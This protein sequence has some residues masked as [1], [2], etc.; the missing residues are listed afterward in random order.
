MSLFKVVQI[1]ET[2]VPVNFWSL[3]SISYNALT[4][5]STVV[6]GGWLNHSTKSKGKAPLTTLSWELPRGAA[7]QLGDAVEAFAKASAL[8]HPVLQGATEP[9]PTKAD[10]KKPGEAE[11]ASDVEAPH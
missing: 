11:E 3:M 5:M 8:K 1:E 4:G 9:P 2:G 10:E 6:Y 7:P